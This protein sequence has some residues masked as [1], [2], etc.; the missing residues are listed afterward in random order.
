LLLRSRIEFTS[1]LS[2]FIITITLNVFAML[3]IFSTHAGILN[4]E[5]LVSGHYAFF[6]KW[7][8]QGSGNGQ[9][10][11]PHGID[12]DSSGR[13]YVSDTNNNRIQMFKLASPCPSGTTQI[14]SGVCFIRA[15]GS[16]GS[17]NGQ[18]LGP[19]GIAVDSSGR[20]YV[21]DFGNSRIQ[22]FKANGVFIK[23][24][25]TEGS[26][27]GQFS[28]P[29]RIAVDSSGHVYVSDTGNHR[30]QFF[31]LSNP[32][33]AGTTQIT[34]GVC[35]VKKWGSPGQGTGQFDTPVGVAIDSSGNVY[36]VEVGNNRVQKFTNIGAFIGTWGTF[37]TSNGQ[38]DFP[39]GIALD[40]SGKVYVA[41]ASSRIQKFQIQRFNV[42]LP[43]PADTTQ[44]KFGVCFITKWG[45]L[46]TGNGQFQNPFDA[47]VDSSGRVYVTDFRNNR[48]QVFYWKPSD[49]GGGEGGNEPD[50]A[51]K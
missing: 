6:N 39:G 32:C 4:V 31:Q 22:I 5:A 27:N 45:T 48:I 30:I 29:S 9:F 23:A 12:V 41:D 3:L 18:F 50:I 21:V 7:G 10:L 16:Q 33:P 38:F 42:T 14:V 44:I 28:R 19:R 1:R 34:S 43:C 36:V 51:I 20:V 47:A 17:G 13:V 24:W 25:G 15:W 8:S 2:N 11:G 46:G 40:S 37:G 49:V 35:F 26:G